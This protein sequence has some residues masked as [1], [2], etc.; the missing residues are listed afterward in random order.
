MIETTNRI[1]EKQ[2]EPSEKLIFEKTGK[3]WN[4][5]EQI[6]E[7][8]DISTSNHKEFVADFKKHFK[9]DG[10][11]ASLI[12]IHFKSLNHIPIISNNTK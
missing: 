9:L 4:E 6:L 7:T 11:I 8:T 10:V 5:W 1:F 2:P 12:V 3:L